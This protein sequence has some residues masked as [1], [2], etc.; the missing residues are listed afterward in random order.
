MGIIGKFRD[1]PEIQLKYQLLFIY[2]LAHFI[3]STNPQLNI[4]EC[5]DKYKEATPSDVFYENLKFI[6]SIDFYLYFL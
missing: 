1:K 4:Q 3:H 6:K 5:L 2:Q